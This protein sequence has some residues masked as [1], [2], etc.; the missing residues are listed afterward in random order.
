MHLGDPDKYIDLLFILL[1]PLYQL[2]DILAMPG[3]GRKL[4]LNNRSERV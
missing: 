4:I 2:L 3:A 1:A